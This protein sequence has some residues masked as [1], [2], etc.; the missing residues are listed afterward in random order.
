MS[1]DATDEDTEQ[2]E[3]EP[4]RRDPNSWEQVAAKYVDMSIRD[5]KISISDHFEDTTLMAQP[6]D[7]D[8]NIG[9]NPKPGEIKFSFGPD[10]N[11]FTFTVPRVEFER[12]MSACANEWGYEITPIDTDSTAEEASSDPS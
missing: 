11:G 5:G 12:I 7:I 6:S 10:S 4:A 9:E 8:F 2:V 1:N 3:I